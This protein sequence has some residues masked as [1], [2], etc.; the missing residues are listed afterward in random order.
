MSLIGSDVI[1]MSH[2]VSR[3]YARFNGDGT[4]FENEALYLVP[5]NVDVNRTGYIDKHEAFS[6]IRAHQPKGWNPTDPPAG[7]ASDVHALT[8]DELGID[9]YSALMLFTALGSSLDKHYGVDAWVEFTDSESGESVIV[10]LDFTIN[11]GKYLKGHK[12]DVIVFGRN[13]EVAAKDIAEVFE[14]R[15]YAMA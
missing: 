15:C 6:K 13:A 9:D 10:T 4:A 5:W 3:N 1:R 8:C 11:S 12:A 2:G 7:I 14:R